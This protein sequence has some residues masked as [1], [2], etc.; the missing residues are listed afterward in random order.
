MQQN[1]LVIRLKPEWKIHL[2]H[3]SS[4][5]G[6]QGLKYHGFDGSPKQYFEFTT[7]FKN[8]VH[9]QDYL[10]ILQKRV[11]LHQA[12]KGEVKRSIHGYRDDYEGYVVACKR[13]KY[14]FD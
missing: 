2:L 13:I 7:S 9:E 11:Y 12:V 4:N 1:Q 6:F 8:L 14:I 10:L 5:K 3:G